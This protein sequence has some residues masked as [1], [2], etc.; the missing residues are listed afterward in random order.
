[1]GAKIS[2]LTAGHRVQLQHSIHPIYSARFPY[3]AGLRDRTWSQS[4][5][6]RDADLPA[7]MGWLRRSGMAMESVHT[8]VCRELPDLPPSPD[9]ALVPGVGSYARAAHQR[10][11][12]GGVDETRQR[13]DRKGYVA[14][15]GRGAA[16]AAHLLSAIQERA[17]PHPGY[18][19]C[20]LKGAA[21]SP[22]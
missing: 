2:P 12:M 11:D 4:F 22:S 21:L 16:V 19:A 14:P 9:W 8:S 17:L 10:M 18:G 5:I 7:T 15:E 6:P 3:Q 1:M 13:A 20:S